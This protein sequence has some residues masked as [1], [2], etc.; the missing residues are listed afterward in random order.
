MGPAWDSRLPTSH[1]SQP[2]IVLA[3]CQIQG[4]QMNSRLHMWVVILPCHSSCWLSPSLT[5]SNLILFIHLEEA[6]RTLLSG[7]ALILSVQSREETTSVMPD[8]GSV[9]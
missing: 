2:N 1:P 4:H 8:L 6:G 5:P 9:N 7:A 3:T